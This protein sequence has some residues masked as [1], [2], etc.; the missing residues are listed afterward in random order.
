[1]RSFLQNHKNLETEIFAFC[2]IT[3]E[4]IEVQHLQITVWTSVL[5]KMLVGEKTA[6]NG[7]KTDFYQLQILGNTLY[8]KDSNPIPT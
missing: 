5:W 3:F 4:P 6:R 8:Y 7:R 2:V 1:M